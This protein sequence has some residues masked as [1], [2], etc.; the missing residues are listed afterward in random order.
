MLH[1]KQ[2]NILIL[3]KQGAANINKPLITIFYHPVY[4]SVYTGSG[5]LN[6]LFVCTGKAGF[7]LFTVYGV[8]FMLVYF[9]E[10]FK[11]WM[12]TFKFSWTHAFLPEIS[13]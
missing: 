6:N 2:V 4:S 12:S 10:F 8:I 1:C 9:H 3:K 7:A 13:I 11:N 5:H